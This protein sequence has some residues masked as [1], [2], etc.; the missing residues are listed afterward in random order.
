MSEIHDMTA[1]QQAAAIRAGDLSPT[2]I[3]AHYIDRIRDAD[4]VIGAFVT[5]TEEL[6]LEQAA[7]AERGLAHAR[8]TGQRLGP[9]YGVPVAIKDVAR[10]EDVRHTQGSAVYGDDVADI[11]DHV[12]ARLKQAG[13]VILGTTNTPEFA[14]PCYTENLVGPPTR[15]PWS[16]EHSPGGSS[17]GSAAAVAARLAPIAHG[18]D[19][20]GSVRIP[21]SACG[22]VGLK[23]SRG[24]VSNGP[25][26]HEVTGL[27]VH[28]ALGRSVA[29]TAA[30]LDA[31]SGVMPGDAFT[32]P[33]RAEP[34]LEGGVGHGRRR[35]A[36]MP[37]P[38]VPGV[39]AHPD[40]LKAL[41]R[42]TG[43]LR[44]AGHS[45]EEVEMSPDQGVADAFARA[46]SVNAASV[47]VDEDEEE[48]L[49]PFTR[50]MRELG[51]EVTGLE[52][53]TALSTF[54]GIGQMLADLFFATYDLILTPT[55]AKPPARVGE[56]TSDDDQV[57]NYDRM[58]AFMPYTPM[59]NIAGLPAISLPAHVNDEGLPIGVM[60]G[61]RYGDE[62]SVLALATEIES[63]VGWV[64]S[65]PPPCVATGA[66]TR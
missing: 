1:L 57:V 13:L 43:L 60:V 14:L 9:L 5:V 18:T 53:H 39:S 8:R 37:D 20:G 63:T 15:N 64:S 4:G 26:D 36:V 38:M 46:W 62:R 29:D 32:A 33:P 52:L 27:S 24:R 56:F 12:V 41:E 48:L 30:L 17:G 25:I 66:L 44:D 31:M 10:I 22:V 11:D 59:Y 16:L 49:T 61:G 42:V 51:R 45:V 47:I 55:L 54:R 3:A 65:P 40:C 35:I 21:A 28:G 19:A 50:Y 7:T 6:A 2:E 34:G 23:P 58:T